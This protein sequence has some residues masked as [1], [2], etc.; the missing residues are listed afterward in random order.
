MMGSRSIGILLLLWLAV[1]TLGNAPARAATLPI[2]NAIVFVQQAPL[3]YTFA[4]ASDIF[5]NF[6]GYYPPEDQPVGGGLFRLDP[7]GTL[8]DLTG[9]SDVAV[10]DPEVSWDGTKVLFSMKVGGFGRWQVWEVGIFGVG[11]RKVSRD[12]GFHDLDPAYLPDGRIVFT[13]DRNRWSDGYENLPSAQIAVMGA[14]GGGVEVLKQHMAG[15]FNPL[16]GSDGMLYFT[17]W[18]FHDRRT[19]IGQANSDFDVN[20]FLLWK[21][22]ADGSGLDHPTFGTHTL[23]D[24]AGGYV[25]IR[26]LP[27]EP[28]IFLGLLAD[29]FFTFGGGAIVRIEPQANQNLD[30]PIFRTP[31][32]F[33]RGAGNAA[34][35]WRSPYPLADG[36]IVA[37]WSP[38]PVYEGAVPLPHWRL[39]VMAADGSSQQTLYEHA[40]LWSWQPV[41]VRSRSAPPLAP[42]A[43][44]PEFPYAIINAFDV[45]LRGVNEDLV[46]NGDFQPVPAHGEITEVRVLRQNVRTP[47][48]YADFPDHADPDV[49]VIGSAPV[50]ADDSFAVIVPADTPIQWELLNAA[51]QVVVRERFGTEL[52]AGELRQC[53]GCHTPHDGTTGKTTNQ[54]LAAPTNLSGQNVDVDGNGLVDLL[55]ALASGQIFTDGFESGN[56]SAWAPAGG[57]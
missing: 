15:H 57:P 33:E 29:E 44:R 5:G 38:G 55:E 10:R 9:L 32:V 53:G 21:M 30:E 52:K 20:R 50:A 23:Y 49:A 51:G 3:D 39:V 24:F 22:F 37:A 13:T 35:R 56:L 19:G 7:D 40:E 31:N 25:E 47:N 4:T 36:G 27:A 16:V 18:D 45:T 6:Q 46:L 8:T 43:A 12:A 17:Q 54:A 48:F 42:G 34:G 2:S 14:D 28:G 26:E 41:E 11:L 1:G